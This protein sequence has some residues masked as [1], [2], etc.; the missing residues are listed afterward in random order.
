MADPA[1][2]TRVR[3]E[4]HKNKITR[5]RQKAQEL[6]AE[7][8]AIEAQTSAKLSRIQKGLPESDSCPDCWVERGDAITIVSRTAADPAHFDRWA[9][10]KCGYGFDVPTGL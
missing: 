5:E 1:D 4:Q 8:E 7:A 10:P 6:K 2:E 3:F 9:C